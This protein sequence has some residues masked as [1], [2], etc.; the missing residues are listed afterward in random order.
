M[1]FLTLD[2]L[3]EMPSGTRACSQA[4]RWFIQS[5]PEGATLIQVWDACPDWSWQ[6]SFAVHSATQEEAVAF[7]RECE[8]RA[9]KYAA[10]AATATTAENAADAAEAAN[11][12]AN[13][14]ADTYYNADCA[15]AAAAATAYYADCATAAGNYDAEIK[16]QVA[17]A[18][19]ILFS[20]GGK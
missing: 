14:D 16:I 1:R 17:W 3:L 20:A 6:V 12:A 10:D 4:R 9:A 5:F 8:E 18:K 7:A 15:A 11:D 13:Y 19:R 2:A